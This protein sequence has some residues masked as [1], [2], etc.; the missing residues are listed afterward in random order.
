MRAGSR[1]RASF[2]PGASA[3]MVPR[4]NQVPP[5]YCARR[6]LGNG[7]SRT[8]SESMHRLL[9]RLRFLLLKELNGWRLT[10]PLKMLPKIILKC[11]AG[12][13][14]STEKFWGWMVP[15]R[16]RSQRS[17][18]EEPFLQAGSG[19]SDGSTPVPHRELAHSKPD[20]GN[21]AASNQAPGLGQDFMLLIFFCKE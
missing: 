6:F 2:S 17:P 16:D 13:S 4:E 8:F 10:H 7:S 9:E 20:L 12:V 11:W 3:A 15:C 21:K 19:V 1:T 18:A 5:V 14:P